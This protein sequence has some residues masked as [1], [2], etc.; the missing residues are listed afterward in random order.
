MIESNAP[1]ESLLSQTKN[2]LQRFDLH[3]KKRLGQHFLVNSGILKN[4]TRAAE[5]SS[6]DLVLEVG[7]GLGIL[8]R[9]LVGS[10]GWVCAIELDTKLA[11]LL[12]QTLSGCQN[13][14]IINQDVL[15]VEPLDLILAEKHKIPEVVLEPLRYKLVANLPYYITAPII[16][17]F[18]EAKL[19]PQVM[20]I[21]VQKEVARNIVAEPGNLGILAISVQFYGKPQ[22]ISYVP[23]CNFYPAPR[24]DSAILKIEVSAHPRLQVTSEAAFFRIV[25]AGFCAARKQIGNS[26][27]QGLDLPKPK[28]LSLLEQAGVAPQK[29]AETLSLEEWAHLERIFSEADYR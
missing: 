25:R 23:A 17:H 14:S 8:T 16:R 12:Q 10:A 21:M 11:E 3:A 26:L 1:H 27:A 15:E 6:S 4:I 9:E 7:P 5:L 28:V 19:K 29:R 24:V 20:V 13:I 2:L 22:I 18:C